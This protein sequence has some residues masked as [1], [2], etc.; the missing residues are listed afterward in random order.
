MGIPPSQ[1]GTASPHSENN[2][3]KI[4]IV[5]L[6]INNVCV[7]FVIFI[8]KKKK[9]VMTQILNLFC[10]FPVNHVIL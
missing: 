1:A 2:K 10:N 3:K 8:K 4:S 9:K 7:G 5:M 6:T